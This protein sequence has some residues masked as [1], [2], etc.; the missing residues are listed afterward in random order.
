MEENH[1]LIDAQQRCIHIGEN[2]ELAIPLQEPEESEKLQNRIQV[3]E[4]KPIEI[5]NIIK[6]EDFSI[7]PPRP[8]R[9][10]DRQ[11]IE[12]VVI[13]SSDPIQVDMP[14]SDPEDLPEVE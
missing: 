3:V 4:S 11:A 2:S 6:L 8:P 12:E 10:R 7:P 13:A 14:L 1:V 5:I 9:R